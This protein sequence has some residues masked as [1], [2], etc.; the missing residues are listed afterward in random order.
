MNLVTGATGHLGNVLVRELVEKGK[1]VRALVLPN[2]TTAPI[3]ELEVEKVVGDVLEPESLKAA[4]DGVENVYHLA[5]I[6]S[7]MPGQDDLM[8]KVNL[9]GARNVALAALDSGVR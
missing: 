7:I 5:G 6:V 3:D 8:H 2:E 1:R 9:E 4:M